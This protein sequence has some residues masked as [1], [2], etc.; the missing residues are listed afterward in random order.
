MCITCLEGHNTNEAGDIVPIE[1]GLELTIQDMLVQ[2]NTL[3]S[4]DFSAVL[5]PNMFWSQ[6]TF[7]KY[8][9]SLKSYLECE[10]SM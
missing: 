8:V 10:Q 7:K 2:L 1:Q 3:S 6:T 9:L 4:F 5:G